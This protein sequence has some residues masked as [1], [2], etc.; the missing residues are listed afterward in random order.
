VFPAN[1][2]HVEKRSL[3]PGQACCCRVTKLRVAEA[4]L[5]RRHVEWGKALTSGSTQMGGAV[6]AAVGSGVGSGVSSNVGS[7]GPKVGAGGSYV[8]GA[9]G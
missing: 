3:W 9:E 6:G 4:V 1:W 2:E 7:V 8:E 5:S